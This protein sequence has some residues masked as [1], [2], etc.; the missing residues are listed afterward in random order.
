MPAVVSVY[1]ADKPGFGVDDDG[2]SMMGQ[3]RG[4]HV[5]ADGAVLISDYKNQCVLRFPQGAKKGEIIAGQEKEERPTDE[6][7]VT[8]RGDI[9]DPPKSHEIA[10]LLTKPVD[11][12]RSPTGELMV[13]ESGRGFLCSFEGVRSK[14][15]DLIPAPGSKNPMNG[16]EGIKYPRAF[17]IAP[18]DALIICDTWS[19]RILRFEAGSTES[20]VLAGC[21]NSMGSRLDQLAF[22]SSIALDAEGALLV[23]DT[24][25]HRVQRFFPGEKCASTAAGSFMCKNG[26]G[27]SELDS[28][29][30][31]CVGPGGDLFIADRGNAR[32]LRFA[33]GAKEGTVV[34]GPDTLKSPWAICFDAKGLLYVS[35]DRKGQVFQ[36]DLQKDTDV[37]KA[38]ADE[39][40]QA[41]QDAEF[42]D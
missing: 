28:P 21:P 3:P 1:G 7:K 5:D 4:L 31:I 18:D 10:H 2:R 34:L 19:H 38:D 13:L 35:D 41:A 26:E 39:L 22:P 12:A 11:V 14:S 25:N 29:A 6:V 30:G 15:Q 33:P 17:T 9:I 42:L 37:R 27:L 8:S 20:T 16:P 40:R 36:I 32:V 24:N 23:S